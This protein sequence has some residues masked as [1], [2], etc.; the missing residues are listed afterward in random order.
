[1]SLAAATASAC[2]A[3]G[4]EVASGA[5]ATSSSACGET[6]QTCCA[7][8]ERTCKGELGCAGGT[9]RDIV[10]NTVAYA[11]YCKEELGFTNPRAKLPYLSC[12]DSGTAGG[13]RAVTGKQAEI[14]LSLPNGSGGKT[15]HNLMSNGPTDFGGKDLWD[16]VFG[17]NGAA[18]QGCD[19]PNY[20]SSVCDPFY[21]L[22]VFQPDAQ[23]RDI[24]AAIHCRD[25]SGGSH[26]PVPSTAI[27]AD[28]RKRAY[29]DL[30]SDATA[31]QR[32][33]M[34]AQYNDTN[35]IVLIMA[36]ARSGKACFFHVQSPYFGTH[37]PAPDDESDVTNDETVSRIWSELPVT[38][39]FAKEDATHRGEWLRNGDSG[40]RRPDN[41]PCTS[42]HDSGPWMHDPFIDSA[43]VLP[44]DR[45]SR[46]YIPL[47][48]SVHGAAAK[49][50]KTDPVLPPGA[51]EREPQKCTS[52]HNIG[53]ASTCSTWLDRAVGWSYPTA[54]SALSK[55][56]PQVGRYM[57]HQH[58]ATTKEAYYTE[59]GAHLDAL[60]CCCE[61]PD[62]S[63]CRRVDRATPGAEGERGTG[64][65]SCTNS[66]AG[67]WHQPCFEGGCNSSALHCASDRCVFIDE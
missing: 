34:F 43:D 18:A 50:V 54:A 38:P 27:S 19:D 8:P 24:T 52:C 40:Y 64:E 28:A 65:R 48:Q 59:N 21:R 56:E 47:P 53:S 63:G 15:T 5:S 57:P 30:P 26:K 51:T 20:L 60:K 3:S 16:T 7:L 58:D 4:S 61:H 6:G 12:Y 49:L 11:E 13:G 62:W 55:T 9:C 14:V 36:N 22:N 25:T 29:L 10:S 23:N 31:E 39:P 1:M 45:A 44:N 41:M 46:P 42:C 32:A 33:Q 17:S 2:G 35:E 66:T 67:G 37:F